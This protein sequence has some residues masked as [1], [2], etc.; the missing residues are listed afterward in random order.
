[1][2]GARDMF[3]MSLHV[4][5]T[6]LRARTCVRSSPRSYV[7]CTPLHLLAIS[8]AVSAEISLRSPRKLLISVL[9]HYV[10]KIKVSKLKWSNFGKKRQCWLYSGIARLRR[11]CMLKKDPK[12]RL[13]I[14][15]VLHK[16]IMNHRIQ[17]FLWTMVLN[18]EF[19]L[20]VI[21]GDRSHG[22]RFLGCSSVKFFSKLNNLFFGYFDPI[23]IFFDNKNKYFSG[24]P[25]RYF[26]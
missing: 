13:T 11:L 22:V 6:L 8:V 10:Y 19:V 25:K 9:K 5:G 18:V 16:A 26:G 15:Q 21:H 3:C 12:D 2:C 7:W 24:W 17:R 4:V 1:M 20:T 23:N 14:N